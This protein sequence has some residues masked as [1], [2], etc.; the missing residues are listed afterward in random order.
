MTTKEKEAIEKLI[1]IA[2]NQQKIIKKLAQDMG[3]TAPSSAVS[4]QTD[5]VTK[6]LVPY[7]QQAIQ[8]VGAKANYLV[9]E[10]N[11]LDDGTLH[12]S[13]LQPKNYDS[14]E[15]HKIRNKFKELIVGKN[16]MD[17]N[18]QQKPVHAVNMMGMTV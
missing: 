11:L 5:D 12:V 18:G 6:S 4:I 10:G 9:Q 7:L 15:Y 3:Y 17:S 16:L 14:D 1:K 2:E 13:V 8:E